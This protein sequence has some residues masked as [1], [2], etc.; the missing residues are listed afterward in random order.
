MTDIIASK[1]SD[2]SG[3]QQHLLPEDRGKRIVCYVHWYIQIST[4]YYVFALPA[5]SDMPCLYE[6]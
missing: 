3:R 6:L 4:W 2:L 5:C 1:I